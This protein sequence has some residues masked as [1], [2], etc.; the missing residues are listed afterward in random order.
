MGCN[1]RRGRS[2]GRQGAKYRSTNQQP[3]M[4][5]EWSAPHRLLISVSAFKFRVEKGVRCHAGRQSVSQIAQFYFQPSS[6]FDDPPCS[7][8]SFKVNSEPHTGARPSVRL[9]VGLI[10]HA[11]SCCGRG[12]GGGDAGGEAGDKV[13]STEAQTNNREWP[14]DGPLLVGFQFPCT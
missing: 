7:A 2:S 1:G 11:R 14:A 3:R 8:A 9:C 5:R 4:P 12:K 10:R 6:N 13:R